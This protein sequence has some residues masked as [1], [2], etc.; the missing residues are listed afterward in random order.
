MTREERLQFCKVCQ[1]R[2]MDFQKG[3]VCKLTDE[4]A[5]FDGNCPNFQKDEIEAE[6]V[7]EKRKA[8]KPELGSFL[9][10]FLYVYI[11]L[12]ILVTLIV[13]IRF[14]LNTDIFTQLLTGL[15]LLCYCFFGG[16]T[17]YAFLKRRPDAIFAGKFFLI[18]IIVS[19]LLQIIMLL[20]GIPVMTS[21]G[22]IAFAII[23][24]TGFLILLHTS[25]SAKDLIPVAERKITTSTLIMFILSLIVL[26]LNAILILLLILS[27]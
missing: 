10:F 9:K 7:A 18:M 6:A 20:F 21:V 16:Y 3:I 1:N 15:F 11:P 8:D 23:V 22:I 25:Q 19:R 26:V 4:Q 14:L 5:S 12:G 13:N 27:V 17:I 24:N 2:T